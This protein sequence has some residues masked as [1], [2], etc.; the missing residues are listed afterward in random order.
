M[1][2]IYAAKS[3]GVDSCPMAGFDPACYAKVLKLPANLVP[4]MLVPIG[5][6]ADK[7]ML[8][9]RFPKEDILL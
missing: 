1:T 7:P 2:A 9:V 5:Y 8:K 6:P 3:L 4:T